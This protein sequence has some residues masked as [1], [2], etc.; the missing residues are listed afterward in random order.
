MEPPTTNGDADSCYHPTTAIDNEA[1]LK[2][3]K[4]DKNERG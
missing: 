1:S 3:F 4:N 2:S